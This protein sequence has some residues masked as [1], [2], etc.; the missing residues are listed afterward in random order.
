M[1][2]KAVS[3]SINQSI[4]QSITYLYYITKCVERVTASSQ[5]L[6]SLVARCCTFV[7]QIDILFSNESSLHGHIGP[8]GLSCN[9]FKQTLGGRVVR[10]NVTVCDRG[11]GSVMLDIAVVD[12][13]MIRFVVQYGVLYARSQSILGQ[14]VLLCAQCYITGL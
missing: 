1:C 10:R 12:I 6:Y 4:N 5:I 9:Y 11:R 14:H 8:K 13:Y 3:Q 2:R 7:S